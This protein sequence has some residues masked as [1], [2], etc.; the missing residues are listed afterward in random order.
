MASAISDFFRKKRSTQLWDA[1]EIY[2]NKL[3]YGGGYAADNLKELKAHKVTHIMNVA[4]DVPNYHPNEF[5]YINLR[6]R[7]MGQDEG[8]SRVF[9]QAFEKLDEIMKQDDARVLVHCAAGRNRSAT[10]TI[11]YVMHRDGIQ[12]D[13][14]LKMVTTKRRVFIMRD[15][16]TQLLQYEKKLYGKNTLKAEAF[17]VT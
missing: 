17:L 14:A 8:I 3:Y 11:A 12:L 6:V 5:T 15:N 9:D 16:R 1:A 7:D 13:K 4:D 2:D 10:I